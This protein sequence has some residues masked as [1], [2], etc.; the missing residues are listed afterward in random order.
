MVR[1]NTVSSRFLRRISALLDHAGNSWRLAQEVAMMGFGMMGPT[2]WVLGAL[3]MVVIW[4]GVWWALSTFVFR[5]RPREHAPA[6]RTS[7]PTTPATWD[8]PDF[9]VGNARTL[10]A[11]GQNAMF[12]PPTSAAL[13]FSSASQKQEATTDEP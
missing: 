4:G 5:W 8:R 9:S 6:P 11:T 1:I 3:A 7:A 10:D 12:Q 2:S 13:P